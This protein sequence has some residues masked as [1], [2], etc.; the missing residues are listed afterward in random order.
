MTDLLRDIFTGMPDSD[1]ILVWQSATKLSSWFASPIDIDP[2]AFHR[3]TYFGCGARPEAAK[4]GATKRGGNALVSGI[5]AL[6][7][8]VDLRSPAHQKA[9]LPVDAD[10]ALDLVAQAYPDVSPSTIVNSGHGLQLWYYL[11]AWT[12]IDNSNRIAIA[13][14]LSDFSAQW[15]LVCTQAGY[16]ADSVWDLSRV[17]R[18]PGTKNCKLSQDIRPIEVILHVPDCRYTLLDLRAAAGPPRDA[19]TAA[20]K[21]L[22][23]TDRSAVAH[24]ETQPLPGDLAEKINCLI[25]VDPTIAATWNHDNPSLRDQSP[26]AYD[27]S[28]AQYCVRAGFTQPETQTVLRQLRT[29]H[30]IPQKADSYY[31]ATVSKAAFEANAGPVPATSPTGTT[32]AT[33][34]KPPE[35]T[36]KFESPQAAWNLISSEL[37]IQA[38]GLTRLDAEEPAYELRL[39][40]GDSIHFS[41]I[42]H[43][44]S[45]TKCR[46]IIA[47][48]SHTLPPK[49]SATRWDNIIRA[50]LSYV[51]HDTAGY[52]TTLRGQMRD[53]LSAFLRHTPSAANMTE[54]LQAAAPWT[55]EDGQTMITAASLRYWIA[56]HYQERV[57]P[58][59]L[60]LALRAIGAKAIR[61]PLNSGSSSAWI[62]P[63]ETS[64]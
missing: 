7:L 44:T 47:A 43:L 34:N 57:A 51:D 17:M 54:G 28:M 36:P 61:L 26:S 48:H 1:L 18:L 55:D 16:D 37:G 5:G 6:W 12:P 11:D 63:K 32:T 38:I 52:E 64:Q 39:L 50:A 58:R 30:S 62:L 19:T 41:C 23:L 40:D 59:S 22:R 45:Q 27:M 35:N 13:T 8:D 25:A 46:N 21:P 29:R 49:K 10:E 33:G 15:R 14:L 3:D 60:G 9:A 31:D 42:D 56:I 4:L 53:W 2:Q 24:S 20:T